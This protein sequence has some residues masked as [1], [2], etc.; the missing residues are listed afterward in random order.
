M[1]FRMFVWHIVSLHPWERMVIEIAEKSNDLNKYPAGSVEHYVP[2]Y[3]V[4]KKML[5]EFIIS[6]ALRRCFY[7]SLLDL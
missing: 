7:L 2:A 1:L 5:S 6:L 4:K 3:E